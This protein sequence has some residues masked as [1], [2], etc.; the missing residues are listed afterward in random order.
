MKTPNARLIYLFNRYYNKTA[1]LQETEELFK[2]LDIY[3]DDEDLTVLLKHAWEQV[4]TQN[5]VFGSSKSE[6][7]LHNILQAKS[8]KKNVIGIS[9]KR[10]F[11][12]WIKICAAAAILIFIGIG[13]CLYLNKPLSAGFQEKL[14]QKRLIHDALPGGN[15]AVLTLADGKRIV[16]DGAH[17][18]VLAKQ[19]NAEVKKARN[20]LL[21]YNSDNSTA[22]NQKITINTISTPRGGQYQVVLSDGSKVWLNAASSIQFP[23][24]FKGKTRDVVITGEAYF[25]VAR[26]AAMP[27]I[28]KTDH[29]VIEVLGTHFNVMAY[30]D[31]RLM[32]TT[33]LEGSVKVRF[34]NSTNFLKPGQQALLNAAGQIK[35]T[36]NVDVDDEIAWKNGVFQFR[37]D[38]I[39]TIMRQ[40]ARWY[41]VNI[42]YE[43]RIPV[44]QFTGKI[45]RNVNA[46]ELLNMLKYTG[47]NFQIEGKN[48]IIMK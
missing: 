19:G 42:S 7:I 47:V 23:S 25:E 14:V 44:R 3:A 12:S 27:F 26:N 5:E 1:T 15:K 38:D 22:E 10:S 34:G 24:F 37:D 36:D 39:E 6:E 46:S 41:D 17:N 2:L 43:G 31:E 32:K 9:S 18:G 20:G 48:I 40:V 8:E 45:S 28:V 21:V 30:K 33:L 16:L 13:A 29:A 35:I 4:K 11:N